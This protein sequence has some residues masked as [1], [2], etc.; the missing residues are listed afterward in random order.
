MIPANVSLSDRISHIKNVD[1]GGVSLQIYL[2][3]CNALYAGV[4]VRS[5]RHG[6]LQKLR[7]AAS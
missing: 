4:S 7:N 2:S 3:R 5:V 1:T 6:R